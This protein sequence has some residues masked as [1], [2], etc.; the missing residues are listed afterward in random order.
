MGLIDC[1]RATICHRYTLACPTPN[2]T[3]FIKDIHHFR[4]LGDAAYDL[5]QRR[6]VEMAVLLDGIYCPRPSCSTAYLLDADHILPD[7]R[8]YGHLGLSRWRGLTVNFAITQNA[9]FYGILSN[10][11]KAN[12]LR[13]L[14]TCA[15]CQ[16]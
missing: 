16:K 14:P 5:I 8:V 6:A 2:C 9:M 11:M 12:R 3:G 1:L 10:S 15:D 4:L 7:Q 13:L